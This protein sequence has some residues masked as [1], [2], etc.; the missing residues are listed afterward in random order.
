[1]I[2]DVTLSTSSSSETDSNFTSQVQYYQPT[3]GTMYFANT[4]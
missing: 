4:S 3:S 1:M 2:F